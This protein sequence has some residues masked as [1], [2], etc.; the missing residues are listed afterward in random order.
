[1]AETKIE[2][3]EKVEKAVMSKTTRNVIIGV[4]IALVVLVVGIFVA[5]QIASNSRVGTYKLTGMEENGTDESSTISVFESL[6]MTFKLEMQN[7]N[8]GKLTMYG[9]EKEMTYTDTEIKYGDESVKY[10]Y[11]NGEVIITVGEG[12]STAKFTFTKDKK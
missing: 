1:M 3:A 5:G 7:D 6:G 11:K 12:D 9:D 10:E 4:V 8:K 2:T